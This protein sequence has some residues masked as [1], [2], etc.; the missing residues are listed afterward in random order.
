MG[1][2]IDIKSLMN[3][4]FIQSTFE[5]NQQVFKGQKFEKDD[6]IY[7][8]RHGEKGKNII[9]VRLLP[10][11]YAS[12][13]EDQNGNPIFF[14]LAMWLSHW[15]D[16]GNQQIKEVC[17]KTKQIFGITDPNELRCPICDY[18]NYKYP[19]IKGDDEA[20]K[21][22][23]KRKAKRNAFVNVYIESDQL[24]PE[25]DGKVK[26]MRMNYQ[27]IDLVLN[28][29]NGLIVNDQI[30]EEAENIFDIFNNSRILQ[31]IA[32]PNKIN[33][34]WTDYE[35]SKFLDVTP[36]MG[37]DKKK[38]AAILDQSY[39]LYETFLTPES[40]KIKDYDDLLALVISV[41]GDDHIKGQKFNDGLKDRIKEKKDKEKNDAEE[42]DFPSP[43]ASSV[44]KDDFEPKTKS[45]AQ[46][47]K[48]T[49]KKGIPQPPKKPQ[50]SQEL[51]D[52]EDEGD[53][54]FDVSKFVKKQEN[55]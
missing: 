18:V 36:F 52:N 37:G 17:P 3:P 26:K 44:D 23:S 9:K 51:F 38:I 45:V 8:P 12:P 55:N 5:Q 53:F 13:V 43:G 14:H 7:K 22:R 11:I 24:F 1:Q 35:N 48:E 42:D 25:N 29:L 16:E 6:T 50:S 32:S 34:D 2:K 41:Y 54:K 49:N 27:L 15:Y 33:N 19:Y 46:T 20:N 39:D 21:E 10:S 40:L 30:I 47:T 28:K 4:D 31:I